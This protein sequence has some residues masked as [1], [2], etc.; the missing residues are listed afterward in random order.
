MRMHGDNEERGRGRRRHG[1]FGDHDGAHDGPFEGRG[2]GRGGDGRGGGRGRH[3][4]PGRGKGGRSRGDVRAAMLLLLAEQPRHGYDLIREIEERSGGAWVPSPGSVYPTLQALEDEGLVTVETVDGRKTAALTDAGREWVDAHPHGLDA[5][6]DHERSADAHGRIR[7]EMMQL[8]D[9]AQTA[10]RR[11]DRPELAVSVAEILAGA[12][13][14][15]YRLLA[16]D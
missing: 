16:E 5:L 2:G 6:L 4:G 8:R 3:G 13:R 10:G 7:A 1:G 12:R 9:A 14:D 11:H 15:I